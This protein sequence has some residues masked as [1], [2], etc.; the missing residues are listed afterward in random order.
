MSSGI[1]FSNLIYQHF[2]LITG[3]SALNLC[4]PNCSWAGDMTIELLPWDA[5][6]DDGNSY[7]VLDP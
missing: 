2:Y 7:M 1:G 3:V 6:T 5:G 4:L